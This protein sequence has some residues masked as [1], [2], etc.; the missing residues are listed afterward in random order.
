MQAQLLN[1]L[2]NWEERTSLRVSDFSE[3]VH[4]YLH[5]KVLLVVKR[6]NMYSGI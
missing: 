3:K 1:S 6:K 2:S 5:T 4:S